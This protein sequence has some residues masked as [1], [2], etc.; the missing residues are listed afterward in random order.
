MLEFCPVGCI[1][2]LLIIT[3]LPMK[4]SPR[5]TR[6]NKDITPM[7]KKTFVIPK[8]T[9]CRLAKKITTDSGE[10]CYLVSEVPSS[11]KGNPVAVH[12]IEVIKIAVTP[13]CVE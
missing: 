1:V 13:D 8:G 10:P 3:L 12:A 4:R 7:G 9:K 11:L 6:L 5:L 2:C